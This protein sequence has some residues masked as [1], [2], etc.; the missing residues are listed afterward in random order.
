MDPILLLENNAASSYVEGLFDLIKIFN[1]SGMSY[2][3]IRGDS[4]QTAYSPSIKRT[5]HFMPHMVGCYPHTGIYQP[6]PI[7]YKNIGKFYMGVNG[8]PIPTHNLTINMTDAYDKLNRIFK[9][10][11]KKAFS[12]VGLTMTN[13]EVSKIS[14]SYNG[15]LIAWESQDVIVPLSYPRFPDNNYVKILSYILPIS[16]IESIQKGSVPKDFYVKS[17]NGVF[18]MSRNVIP[19]E[20]LKSNEVYLTLHKNTMTGFYKVCL[21][22]NVLG[23]ILYSIFD[24]ALV[25]VM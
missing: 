8:N 24:T 18:T 1:Q 20:F 4:V 11:G 3:K 5:G 16:V 12:G 2:I 17:E 19:K 14:V 23:Y 9:E 6:I 25:P 13:G 10:H 21:R 7:R 15:G 22:A